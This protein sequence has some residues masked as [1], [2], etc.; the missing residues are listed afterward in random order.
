[1]PA[2]QPPGS[3]QTIDEQPRAGSKEARRRKALATYSSSP[4]TWLVKIICLGVVDAAAVY[5]VMTLAGNGSWGTL[6]V[7]VLATVLINLVYLVP[8]RFLPAK[9]LAPGLVFL[10]VYSVLTMF[11]TAY[12]SVTNQSDGHIINKSDAIPAIMANNQ[13]RVPNSPTYPA[14]VATKGGDLWLV[15]V[16][17]KTKKV[18]V[19]NSDNPMAEVSGAELTSLGS[20]KSVPGYDLLSFAQISK[21]SK[22][23]SALQA[24]LDGND[25]NKGYLHTTTGSS[26]YL[27][28]S[29]MTYDKATDT[30]TDADGVTY[31]DGGKGAY[32]SDKGKELMPGWRILTGTKNYTDAFTNADIRAPLLR[33][34]LWTFAFAILSV[35]STFALGLFLAIM[36]NDPRVRGQK[37]YRVAMI[38]PY[39]FPG[40]L[41]GLLWSGLLNKE[42]GFV[43]QVLLGGASIPWLSDPTWAKVA[44]LL[45]NLWLG[46]P[47]MFLVSTGALQS[48]PEEVTEAARMDGASA[49]QTFR[50]IKLPLLMVPLAPLLIS[51]FAFNFNNFQLIFM[52]TGGGPRFDDT[53]LNVGSTD[54]LITMVYKLS[55][56]AGGSHQYGL[57][58]AMSIIIFV[59][60]GVISY[61][62]FRQTKRLEELS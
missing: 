7:V 23:V 28:K 49:W 32:V 15:A 22:A 27:Y 54:I 2:S 8:N 39:A 26:A 30:M 24:A 29:T 56:F 10:L 14:A 45:V 31:H 18:S 1:M 36:F 40:F 42:F 43:N 53:S 20:P 5:A 16:D 37:L 33:V 21:D 6:A 57:A 13:A 58:S 25:P 11:Y 50:Q 9:Y 3:P 38:L 12:I 46:F 4:L 35:L 34:V 17:P 52:L 19:G 48:I 62:G 55:G 60:V 41:S 47:Y 59:L 51:S 44:I 61:L